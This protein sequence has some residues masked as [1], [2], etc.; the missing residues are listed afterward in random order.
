MILDEIDGLPGSEGQGAVD[1]LVKLV[2]EAM[3]GGGGGGGGADGGGEEK[4]VRSAVAGKDGVLTRTK[5]KGK[6]K[7][8]LLRRPI[9]CICNDL[10]ARSLRPLKQLA[11]CV[12]FQPPQQQRLILRMAQICQAERFSIDRQALALIN[13]MHNGDIRA[14]LNALQM[15]RLQGAHVDL[16]HLRALGG[17]SLKD[18]S[19]S[20]SLFDLW[21]AVFKMPGAGE[22]KTASSSLAK[23]VKAKQGGGNSE[24]EGMLNAHDASMNTIL[25][26]CHQNYASVKYNDPALEKTLAVL[27]ALG[28]ADITQQFVASRQNYAV[29]PYVKFAVRRFHDCLA[30]PQWPTINYPRAHT[31]A[32]QRGT[33]AASL[34]HAVHS[35]MPPRLA[36]AYG[37]KILAVEAAPFLRTILQPSVKLAHAHVMPA[38]DKQRLQAQV[39]IMAGLGLSYQPIR[40]ADGST[41]LHLDPC[42]PAPPRAAPPCAPVVAQPRA[43]AR[44]TKR[45][46]WPSGF[47]NLTR[48]WLQGS[49]AV[50]IQRN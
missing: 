12:V 10:Y 25:Q 8:P 14:C 17:A 20:S 23:A 40:G 36:R 11:Q 24:L 46:S 47:Q 37:R 18:A 19:M 42:A 45:S 21:T 44:S 2:K 50:S 7:A 13:E 48:V 35:A 5:G 49:L 33:Q 22:R 4:E 30:S 28:D 41:A 6:K 1:V 39:D 27:C 43:A 26:G 32:Q 9:I 15:L 38:Q 31:D 3:G 29:A 34:L 16:K